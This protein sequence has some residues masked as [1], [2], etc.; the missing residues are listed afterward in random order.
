FSEPYSLITVQGAKQRGWIGEDK[1]DLEQLRQ[2]IFYSIDREGPAFFKEVAQKISDKHKECST[3][4]LEQAVLKLVESGRLMV[5]RGRPEQQEKPETL[6]DGSFGTMYA[7]QPDAVFITPSQARA[8]GWLEAGRDRLALSGKEGA[9]KLLPLLRRLGSLY[10][11]G[12][13][14]TI[15]YMDLT[16]LELPG[17]GTLR[18]LLEDVPPESMKALGEVFECLDAV[19][20]MGQETE[21]YLQIDE[22]DEQCLLIQEL[23]AKK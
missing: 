9:E 10:S 12:A 22:P 20:K 23:K 3:R 19:A 2:E 15:K 1:I 11:R 5:Y 4:D 18:L 13:K 16:G 14:S 6:Q 21:A 7:L 8:R 17:G